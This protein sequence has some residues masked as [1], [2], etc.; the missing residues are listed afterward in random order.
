MR[1]LIIGFGSI[2][3]RHY[4]ALRLFMPDAH[5]D[6]VDLNNSCISQIDDAKLFYLG[7]TASRCVHYTCIV[8]S[9]SASHRYNIIESLV[10]NAITADLLILEKVLLQDPALLGRIS[11]LTCQISEKC[12]VNQWFRNFLLQ[13]SI[14]CE[15]DTI[16]SASTYGSDWGLLCNSLHFIDAFSYFSSDPT[17]PEVY[18]LDNPQVIPAKRQGFYDV[19]G[20]F[21]IS[22]ATQDIRLTSFQET[23]PACP[24]Y[25]DI[26]LQSGDTLAF[27]ITR[28][29]ITLHRSNKIHQY[30]SYKISRE[31][32]ILYELHFSGRLIDLPSIHDSILQHHTLFSIARTIPDFPQSDQNYLF[33]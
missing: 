5:I 16:V 2:G 3:F 11:D 26:C 1:F 24:L 17:P 28:N 21:R 7:S 32:T 27:C 25:L 6:V 15:R 20:S 23:A 12:F 29:N 22:H 31:M 9:T 13:K 4:Q 10:S 18:S 30:D 14:L 19:L 8:I 33:T